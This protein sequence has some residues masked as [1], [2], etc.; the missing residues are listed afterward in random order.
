MQIRGPDLEALQQKADQIARTMAQ[1]P[2]TSDVQVQYSPG[3]PELA[4]ILDRDRL[5][6][7]G[8]GVRLAAFQAR[9]ALHG[10]VAGRVR[11]GR[12]SV[13]LRVMLHET[14]RRRPDH[15][16]DCSGGL[17][18]GRQPWLSIIGSTERGLPS[19]LGQHYCML[20]SAR[21]SLA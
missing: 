8:L 18:H 9:L 13:D 17:V 5:R 10:A 21:R 11:E 4:V 14:A 19:V 6:D 1:V 7:R 15:L 3:L 16:A 20:K 2:G 12:R